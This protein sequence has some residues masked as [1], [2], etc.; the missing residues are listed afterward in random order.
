MQR[1]RVQVAI[2]NNLFVNGQIALGQ[3]EDFQGAI[4]AIL[5]EAARYFRM[6]SSD[7]AGTFPTGTGN[8][9]ICVSSEES[10][11]IFTFE[12]VPESAPV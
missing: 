9:R 10:F 11:T 6:L 7:S 5:G 3:L 4:V 12:E 8:A 1:G 2:H